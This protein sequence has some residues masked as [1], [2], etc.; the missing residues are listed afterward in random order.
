KPTTEV[1]DIEVWKAKVLDYI[2]AKSAYQDSK[3]TLA[4]VAQAIGTTSKQV[5]TVINQGFGMNFNDFVNDFRL[6]EVKNRFQRG[7]QA[8]FTI[9]AI[10][11]D[12]GFNSKTTFNRVFKRATGQT[13]LQYLAKISTE[14]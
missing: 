5:S 8:H 3:L 10:A 2:E 7:E 12:C 4:D 9:L 6:R 13:P 1:Q 11:L 14:S